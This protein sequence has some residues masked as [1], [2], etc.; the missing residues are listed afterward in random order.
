MRYHWG[1]GVGH[2]HVHQS[3]SSHQSMGI[4]APDEPVPELPPGGGDTRISDVEDDDE[5]DNSEMA[6]E[7]R[8]FEGWDD[9]ESNDDG[10]NSDEQDSEDDDE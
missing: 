8:E 6:L 10:N 1:L 3:T 7:D 2:L 5:S 4:N 9:V